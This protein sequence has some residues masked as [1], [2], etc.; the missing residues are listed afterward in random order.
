MEFELGQSRGEAGS[1]SWIKAGAGPGP[2]PGPGQGRDLSLDQG[3]GQ[4]GAQLGSEQKRSPEPSQGSD[5]AGA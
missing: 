5:L 2:E 1:F 3:R 4:A